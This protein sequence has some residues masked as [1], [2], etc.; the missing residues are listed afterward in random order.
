MPPQ[1]KAA[2]L[3]RL[4]GCVA[5]RAIRPNCV[6]MERTGMRASTRADLSFRAVFFQILEARM[7][8]PRQQISTPRARGEMSEGRNGRQPGY[9]WPR[10]RLGCTCNNESARSM[11]IIF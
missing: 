8:R 1:A 11:L 5:L 4:P 7:N 10:P 9:Q 2:A 3:S 6:R